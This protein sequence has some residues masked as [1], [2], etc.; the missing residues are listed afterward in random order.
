MTK[1]EP[2]SKEEAIDLAQKAG[3]GITMYGIQDYTVAT[4]A[5]FNKFEKEIFGGWYE[6][7]KVR[8]LIELARE[9]ERKKIEADRV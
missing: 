9:Y 5:H 1:R 7:L 8:K 4:H 3:Y 6:T 2:I